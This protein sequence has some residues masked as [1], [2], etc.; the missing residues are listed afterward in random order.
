MWSSG[1]TRCRHSNTEF[2]ETLAACFL[3][4]E[5]PGLPACYR[6]STKEY[7]KR[8][9]DHNSASLN[10]SK[11][12][13]KSLWS[14]IA[15]LKDFYIFISAWRHFLKKFFFLYFVSLL[16]QPFRSCVDFWDVSS[17]S[18][19]YL[20]QLSLYLLWVLREFPRHSGSLCTSVVA[21][22]SGKQTHSEGQCR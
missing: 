20:K 15:G 5:T 9:G 2:W 18:A 13:L 16:F 17:V 3:H 7:W 4:L 19:V 14:G 8:G 10:N 21:T 6:L 11:N 22:R 12:S 1:G